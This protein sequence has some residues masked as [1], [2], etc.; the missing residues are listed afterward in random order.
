MN[1]SNLGWQH[2]HLKARRSPFFATLHKMKRFRK[3]MDVPINPLS[4]IT[5]W[6]QFPKKTPVVTKKKL[7]MKMTQVTHQKYHILW[8]ERARTQHC[9]PQQSS[10]V[11]HLQDRHIFF[12]SPYCSPSIWLEVHA[13][14]CMIGCTVYSYIL[15]FTSS[16]SAKDALNW[17]WL[18]HWL[19]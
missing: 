4:Q 3:W 16:G 15:P 2:Y 6:M 18:L 12:L 11:L 17:H 8:P 7:K 5:L 19:K 13:K 1:C 10:Y 9:V 14:I